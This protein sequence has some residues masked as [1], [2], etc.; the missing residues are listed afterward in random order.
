M[1][2]HKS[3]PLIVEHGGE[4]YAIPETSDRHEVALYRFDRESEQFLWHQA[5]LS[6]GDYVDTSL[7]EYEGHWYLFTSGARDP[8]TQRLFVADE[9]AA[10]ITNIHNHRYAA[11]YAVDAMAE[12]L[13]HLTISTIGLV[14]TAMVRMAR[15]CW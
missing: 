1:G 9:F 15:A 8:F 5:L 10:P 12:R 14:R 11:T 4:Y 6:D 3:Y 13:C 2:G 7:V